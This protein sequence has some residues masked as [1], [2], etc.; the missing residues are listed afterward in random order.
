[1]YVGTGLKA[2]VSRS[3]PVAAG[4]LYLVSDQKI[5][6]LLVIEYSK[7]Q[8]SLSLSVQKPCFREIPNPDPST[9]DSSRMRD[10]C[11]RSSWGMG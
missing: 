8:E 2:V 6:H 11:S 5:I 4:N 1:M 9:N 10:I 7:Y 3:K